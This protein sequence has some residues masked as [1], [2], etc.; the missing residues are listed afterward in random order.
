[1]DSAHSRLKEGGIFRDGYDVDLDAF[2]GGA[3]R[4]GQGLD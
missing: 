4:G 1:M 2:A 3:S